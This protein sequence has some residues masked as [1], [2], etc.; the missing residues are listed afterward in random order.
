MREEEIVPTRSYNKQ[1]LIIRRGGNAS[2]TQIKDLQ[3]DL[4][5]LGYLPG[6][7]D[8][9][10]GKV[11]ELAVKSLQYDLLHN[12]GSSTR[13]DGNAS[14]SILDYNRGRIVQITGEATQTLA[15]CISDM[16]DDAHI[17]LLPKVDDPKAENNKLITVMCDLPSTTAPIPFLMG[18]LQQES[19]LRHY[20]EP[21]GDDEDTFITVGLDTNATEKYIITSRGY[22]VGQYTLFHHPPRQ[23][24]VNDFMLDV[25]KNT[26][27]S[28]NELREKFDRFVNGATTGTRSDDRI[29]EYGSGPLR[30][31]RYASGDSRYMKDCTQCMRDAGQ[32]D[33]QEG[34]TPVYQGSQVTFIPTQY[35]K[36]ASYSGVPV[37]KNIGCD[38]PYAVRRYNGAGINS[39]HYQAIVLKN[40]LAL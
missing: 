14:V 21:K 9:D 15:E 36:K 37:R 16:L 4:R 40:I 28:M 3:R 24:E 18:V 32:M 29:A 27:K 11:T 20:H 10:F 38:W 26:R 2:I 17:P 13:Q 23:D 25:G 34:S 7:I 19:G 30:P 33:I 12:H 5:Q 8:G 35:Y 31:C 22:G 6:G 39:Y 1:G